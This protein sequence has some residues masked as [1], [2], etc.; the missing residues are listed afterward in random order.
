MMI[1][2]PEKRI[3]SYVAA[4]RTK[5]SKSERKKI[6]ITVFSFL[7]RNV[8]TPTLLSAAVLVLL[9]A[10]VAYAAEDPTKPDFEIPKTHIE[11]RVLPDPKSVEQD[12]V[13]KA[14]SQSEEEKRD[15]VPTLDSLHLEM[16]TLRDELRLLQSTLDL[17]INQI[18]EDQRKENEFLRQEIWR[19]NQQREE[20]GLPD[21]TRIPRPGIGII[22]EVLDGQDFYGQEDEFDEQ[23]PLIDFSQGAILLPGDY[24]DSEKDKEEE[25]APGSGK[26][27]SYTILQ[28]WGRDPDV[29][30][31]I[32]EGAASLKG[33]VGVV[34]A[35]SPRADVE[36]LGRELR[37]Q[38]DEYDN[39][40]IELFDDEEAAQHYAQTQVG[41]SAHRVLSISKHATSGRDIILYI[42]KGEAQ[43]VA[44]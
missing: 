37:K 44:P 27:S 14:L 33:M 20:W 40:N 32:G 17:L 9:W 39:I 8:F 41:D 5:N 11:V 10:S 21:Q 1:D 6:S 15:T 16:Q 2:N 12:P 22:R 34:P 30:A 23:K 3:L 4:P 7:R 29:V 28:E 24:N 31:E 19:L 43:E 13:P 38:Y 25:E 42:K 18:M 26:A 36:Q 35:G